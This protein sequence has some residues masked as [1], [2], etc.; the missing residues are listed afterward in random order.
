MRNGIRH[1][2]AERETVLDSSSSLLSSESISKAIVTVKTADFLLNNDV[3]SHD[4]D[5]R[6]TIIE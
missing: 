3:I 2:K 1:F 5:V 4:V 6:L